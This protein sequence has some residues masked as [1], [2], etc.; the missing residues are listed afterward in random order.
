MAKETTSWQDATAKGGSLNND[1]FGM[2][3]NADGS[4]NIFPASELAERIAKRDEDERVQEDAIQQVDNTDP[5]LE[6]DSDLGLE[7]DDD[8]EDE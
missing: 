1:K 5:F 2:G 4:F 7:D 6:D 8:A 3:E